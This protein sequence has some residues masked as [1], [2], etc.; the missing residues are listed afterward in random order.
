[1][2]VK[3]GDVEKSDFAGRRHDERASSAGRQRVEFD[4][5]P[6]GDEN[7]PKSIRRQSARRGYVMSTTR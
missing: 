4:L 6:G 2:F 3:R 5:G 1:M 7:N